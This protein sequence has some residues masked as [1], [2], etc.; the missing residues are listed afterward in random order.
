M[1]TTHR[2]LTASAVVLALALAACSDDG[3]DSTATSDAGGSATTAVSDATEPASDATEPATDATEPAG[4][5]AGTGGSFSVSISE[6]SALDPALAQEVEGA[7]VVR[8]LFTTLTTLTPELELAP[9]A[10]T[11]W[12]VADDGLTWT[13]ELDPAATFSDGTPVDAGDFVYAIARSADPDLAAPAAYQGYPISGWA[14]VLE[15][16]ASGA[17]GDVPVAGV[18]AVDDDTLV[19]SHEAAPL[20]K[21]LMEPHN[22]DVIRD[23]LKDALGVDWRLR[24]EVG[25]GDQ[26]AAPLPEEPRADPVDTRRAEEDSMIA[27]V[28]KDEDTAPRRDPEEVALELLKTELGARPIDG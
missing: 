2:S 12:S 23:A 8:L 9:G 20:A 5:S 21:R 16:E 7:Q 28:G 24:C 25:T 4:E 3:D 27:E 18:T 14:D 26:P 22:A 6:P 11:E 17:I 10:A 1:K 19:L 15:A 13:F